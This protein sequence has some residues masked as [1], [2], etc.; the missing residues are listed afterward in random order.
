MKK[1]LF[2]VACLSVFGLFVG[3]SSVTAEETN[4]LTQEVFG[5][6][7]RTSKIIR[8]IELDPGEQ[9]EF[10]IPTF[11][12]KLDQ[13]SYTTMMIFK[14]KADN[15]NNDFYSLKTY[16]TH[17]NQDTYTVDYMLDNKDNYVHETYTDLTF[18]DT[19][20]F[21]EGKGTE[22]FQLTNLSIVPMKFKIGY[23][24]DIYD[25]SAGESSNFGNINFKL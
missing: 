22:T 10:K 3:A 24:S 7:P 18:V 1:K 20:D 13:N 2:L 8:E 19:M 4:N 14:F 23:S 16:Y 21:D 25:T 6:T 15:P 9:I 12:Y 5:K 17:P 11:C